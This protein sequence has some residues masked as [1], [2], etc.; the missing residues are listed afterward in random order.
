MG[1]SKFIRADK[2]GMVHEL[3]RDEKMKRL[4]TIILAILYTLALQP[5]KAVWLLKM[6]KGISKGILE[7]SQ[8]L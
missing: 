4:Y 1:V 5:Q 3:Y 8:E 2:E 7:K 6:R